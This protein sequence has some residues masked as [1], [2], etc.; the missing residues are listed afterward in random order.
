MSASSP[1]IASP[2][3]R[4]PAAAREWARRASSRASVIGGTGGNNKARTVSRRESVHEKMVGSQSLRHKRRFYGLER[5]GSNKD[6]FWFKHREELVSLAIILMYY[7]FGFLFYWF[8]EDWS[9]VDTLYFQT[10]TLTTVGY[11]DFSPTYV[12]PLKP[13]S[14]M[15][16]PDLLCSALLSSLTPSSSI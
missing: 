4:A 1:I 11:G 3:P 16:C 10:A 12:P 7:V 2:G 14:A 15:L 9:T 5:E 13:C 6:K 8:E